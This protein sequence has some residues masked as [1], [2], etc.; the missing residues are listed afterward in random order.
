MSMSDHEIVSF[1]GTKVERGLNEQDNELS[2]TR[3]ENFNY[4]MKLKYGDERTNYSEVVTGEAFEAVEWAKPL[5]MRVF[6][7]GDRVVSFVPQTMQDEQLADQ[8]TD[9]VRHTLFE[10]NNGFLSLLNWITDALIYPVGYAKI[11]CDHSQKAEHEEYRGLTEMELQQ[12]LMTD[13]EIELIGSNQYP[14]QMELLYDLE[15]KR[16]TN[17]YKIVFEPCEPDQIIVDND[18]TELSLENADFVCHRV[19]R[20]FSWLVQSGYDPDE[21]NEVYSND[22]LEWGSERT[23]RLFFTD[24]H[25]GATDDD[26]E[27]MREFWV[28]ECYLSLDCDKD[29]V[30][31]RRRIVMI[32]DRIFENE[33]S[34]YLPIVAMSTIPMSHKHTGLS[35]VDI[36]KDLQRVKS[37]LTRHLLDNIYRMNVRRKYVGRRAQ[38]D[39]GTT[40]DQL[41]DVLAEIIECEDETAIREEQVQPIA[42]EILT[43]IKEIEEHVSRRTGVAPQMSLDPNVLR[44]TTMTAFVNALEQASQRIELITRVFAETGIKAVMLKCHRLLRE[45]VNKELAMKIRGSWVSFDPSGW[46]ERTDVSVEVGT[47]FYSREKRAMM[48]QAL[49]QQQKELIQFGIVTP[50]NLYMSSMRLA[51]AMGERTPQLFFTD[52]SQM[53][54]PPPPPPDPNQ[55]AIQAQMQIEAQK[56]QIEQQRIQLD[57]QKAQAEFQLKATEQQIKAA[58]TQQERSQDAIETQQAAAEKA[59]LEAEKN[60]LQKQLALLREA[61]EEKDRELKAEIT[62]AEIEHRERLEVMRQTQAPVDTQVDSKV[63]AV[64]KM[65][66]ESE[67]KRERRMDIL[68]AY[69]SGE[70]TDE[71]LRIAIQRMQTI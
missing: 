9:I 23:N 35:L 40:M 62:R 22:E 39:D 67:R 52:P 55:M 54:P 45:Y 5:I 30:A 61:G 59:R 14:G 17:D 19:R 71:A 31:E 28:H 7:G 44:D 51:D 38:L 26:D 70:R 4:Y 48:L 65:V 10:Q 47:G 2:S 56:R 11:W 43:V 66:Q 12:L 63:D 60:E 49:L 41:D 68:A 69:F 1:I 32:G 58:T 37:V 29:G 50:Q 57:M 15:L 25:P 36:V 42:A 46:R 6:S 13:D 3:K 8:E 33:E 53:P 27:S 24:E 64:G 21:L 34:S 18:L 16:V 20:S